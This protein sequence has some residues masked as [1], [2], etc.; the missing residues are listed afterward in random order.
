MFE[1]TL[2][3]GTLLTI[4]TII[5]TA[6]SVYVKHQYNSDRF[7]KDIVDI[8]LDLKQLNKIVMDLA[9]QNQRLDILESTL[10]EMRHGKGFVKNV[11]I[12]S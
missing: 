8:K 6:A 12:V 2:N 7:L 11:K 10:F 3:V 1:W 9:L 5:F 4:F